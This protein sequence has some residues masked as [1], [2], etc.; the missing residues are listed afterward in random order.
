MGDIYDTPSV[1]DNL[2][3]QTRRRAEIDAVAAVLSR[4]ASRLFWPGVLFLF[5][6][7]SDFADEFCLDFIDPAQK[8]S[9]SMI[10]PEGKI[11]QWN[12]VMAGL[13]LIG[14]LIWTVGAWF[15]TIGSPV[16]NKESVS[17]KM[18]LIL[19]CMVFVY[20]L[21]IFSYSCI[22]MEYVFSYETPIACRRSH[23]FQ[24]KIPYVVLWFFSVFS[25]VLYSVIAAFVV[26]VAVYLA[27]FHNRHD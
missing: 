9:E 20:I 4:D 13:F 11:V 10:G 22:G 23:D 14:S 8:S 21:V 24:D 15:Y 18:K 5:A 2:Q 1:I 16:T 3:E 7:Y 17:A 12:R 19:Q 6:G 27:F 25:V 26:L